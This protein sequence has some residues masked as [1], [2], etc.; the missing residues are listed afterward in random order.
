M[1]PNRDKILEKLLP[2]GPAPVAPS[3]AKSGPLPSVLLTSPSPPD[4]VPDDPALTL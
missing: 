3:E 1:G 2:P 4:A